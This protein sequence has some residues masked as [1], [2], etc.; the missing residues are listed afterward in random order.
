[1]SPSSLGLYLLKVFNI[2]SLAMFSMHL[3]PLRA[4]QHPM[5]EMIKPR[6]PTMMK[7]MTTERT[8]CPS[9]TFRA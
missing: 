8:M 9:A 1:M 6:P 7:I 5:K 3:L 4:P 2:W